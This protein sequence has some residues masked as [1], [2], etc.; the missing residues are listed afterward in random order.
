MNRPDCSVDVVDA[1]TM[2][3]WACAN[4]QVKDRSTTAKARRETGMVFMERMLA[5][6]TGCADGANHL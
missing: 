2:V 1:I 5:R 4:P 3:D 6:G